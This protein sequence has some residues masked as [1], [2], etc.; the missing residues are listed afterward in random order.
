ME[1]REIQAENKRMTW[2][3]K[4][5][6]EKPEGGWPLFIS[7]HGGG[8]APK[9]VNDR[10]W[11]NQIRLYHP[12]SG[13]VVAPRAPTDTWNLWH[14]SHIDPL[15]A[16]LIE[17]FIQLRDVNPD[18]VYLLGYSAGGDG[19]Y[20]VAPRMADRYAAASMMAGHPN[21]ASPLGLRNL[22]FAIF[23]GGKD[24]AYKRNQVAVEWGKK[25]DALKKKDSNGYPHRCVIYPG[26][27]HWMN[28]KDQEA[29]PWMARQVRDVWPKKNRLVPG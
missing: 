7:L 1:A 13:I 28:G 12:E 26:C 10:Q 25:L 24:V 27:G 19:V 9:M 16:R 17:S 8:G 14:Q 15:F 5:F 29:I 20:Q 2:L 22:P 6:G 23:C 18:R 21:E 3:E 11:R 4:T